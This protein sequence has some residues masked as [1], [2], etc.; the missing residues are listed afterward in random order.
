MAGYLRAWFNP[1]VPHMMPEYPTIGSF[2]R[3][4]R[5]NECETFE[6]GLD[7]W[8]A[9][10]FHTLMDIFALYMECAGKYGWEYDMYKCPVFCPYEFH[11]KDMFFDEDIEFFWMAAVAHHENEKRRKQNETRNRSKESK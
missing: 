5:I 8:R 1:Q 4:C 2:Q 3:I 7:F 6:E 10:Q 9:K 11:D